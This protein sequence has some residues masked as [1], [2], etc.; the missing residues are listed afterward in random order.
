MALTGVNPYTEGTAVSPGATL[1]VANDGNL[2]DVTG[3]LTLNGGELLAT[4]NLVQY[5]PGH[6]RSTTVPWPQRPP[7]FAESFGDITV[8][9]GSN[10]WRRRE[11]WGR[12]VRAGSTPT[13]A[14]P[15]SV[16]GATLRADTANCVQS[17][18]RVLP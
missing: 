10:Y 5:G 12:G 16:S 8:N 4:G 9:G 14:P 6:I 18:F 1:S 13:P 7:R 15:R 11:Q 17:E 3:G 2:G